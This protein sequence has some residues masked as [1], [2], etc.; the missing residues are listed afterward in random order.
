MKISPVQRSLSFI[1]TAAIISS[2]F[3]AIGYFTYLT[4][5]LPKLWFWPGVWIY[6]GTGIFLSIGVIIGLLL[7]TS[8]STRR[9]LSELSNL[10]E[11]TTPSYI[12][13]NVFGTVLLLLII[14][15]AAE[16][17]IL[18][19][20]DKHIEILYR[21]FLLDRISFALLSLLL[22]F[23]TSF[24]SGVM[25]GIAIDSAYGLYIW[26]FLP[27]YFNVQEYNTQNTMIIVLAM[28]AVPWIWGWSA[29]SCVMKLRPNNLIGVASIPFLLWLASLLIIILNP[30]KPRSDRKDILTKNH[31]RP[32]HIPLG[33]RTIVIISIVYLSWSS[34]WFSY[35]F[36]FSITNW[37]QSD[38]IIGDTT[39]G[40]SP[41]IT[42]SG[43]AGLFLGIRIRE[44]KRQTISI[45]DRYGLSILATVVLESILV[46]I[47]ARVMNT[48]SYQPE[49]IKTIL[50]LLF[51]CIVMFWAVCLVLAVA[52]LAESESNRFDMWIRLAAYVFIG[53]GLTTLSLSIWKALYLGN[54][55]A[56]SFTPLMGVPIAGSL[57]I[58]NENKEIEP[59][60]SGIIRILFIVLSYI[61]IPIVV[62]GIFSVRN[63]WLG[64]ISST[65]YQILPSEG[66]ES[67]AFLRKEDNATSILW[68][69]TLL[70][71]RSQPILRNKLKAIINQILAIESSSG[72][73]N[74]RI[75]LIGLPYI[76]R[77]DL[78]LPEVNKILQIDIDRAIRLQEAQAIG[79]VLSKEEYLSY[80]HLYYQSL[81]YDL[82][83]IYISQDMLEGN[84]RWPQLRYT[85]KKTQ[86]IVKDKNS[87]WLIRKRPNTSDFYILKTKELAF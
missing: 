31:I 47:T 61:S 37:Y 72:R 26:Q 39:C 41:I 21:N 58:F 6:A 65:G 64:K 13:Y 9:P 85:L 8:F 83:I 49:I 78:L 76:K 20:L 68:A 55:L 2:T 36:R 86:Q 38:M 84:P 66:T 63:N 1:K 24:L 11:D 67:V 60:N 62:G 22:C 28:I 71:Y 29:G 18:W 45:F 54:L 52:S 69:N 5:K 34:L 16:I 30:S 40:I 74:Q 80:Q 43:L 33:P 15:S 87:I 17:T 14:L 32:T 53:I 51:M 44:I 19:Q 70:E 42:I 35:H 56:I 73:K 81:P 82:A 4:Y 75:L 77:S 46:S 57:I 59:Y 23:L 48:H 12:M 10:A 7:P 27:S 25:I 50:A 79:L 3:F